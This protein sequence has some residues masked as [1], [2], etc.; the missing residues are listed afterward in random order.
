MTGTRY[1]SARGGRFRE[2]TRISR[3]SRPPVRARGGDH[4]CP[5]AAFDSALSKSMRQGF[6]RPVRRVLDLRRIASLAFI[7]QRRTLAVGAGGITWRRGL[8]AV[9][10]AIDNYSREAR[11]RQLGAD[12]YHI[13]VAVRDAGHETR[14]IIVKD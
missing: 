1:R 2:A 4:E 12:S 9:I 14:G 11:G 10:D 7:P 8:S 13:M 6:G 5:D 3:R